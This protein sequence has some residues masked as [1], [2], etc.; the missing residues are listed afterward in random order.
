[1]ADPISI[2]LFQEVGMDLF[3]FGRIVEKNNAMFID[4]PSQRSIVVEFNKR[5]PNASS[6]L[7]GVPTE[8][9]SNGGR[10]FTSAEF[11]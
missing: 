8:L 6:V 3:Q 1:M 7:M 9:R 10:Q 4:M 5:S 11:Q 2:R